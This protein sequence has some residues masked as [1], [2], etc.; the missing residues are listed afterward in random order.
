MILYAL[1]QSVVFLQVLDVKQTTDNETVTEEYSVNEDKFDNY[2]PRLFEVNNNHVSNDLSSEISN[3]A[4]TEYSQVRDDSNNG[5]GS[6]MSN[7][8]DYYSYKVWMFDG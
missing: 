5:F 2:P 1:F 7:S 8:L 3:D 4:S 6:H